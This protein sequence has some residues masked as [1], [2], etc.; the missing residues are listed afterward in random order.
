MQVVAHI[1][2]ISA[3][4]P[5]QYP[6]FSPENFQSKNFSQLRDI[7][8]LSIDLFLF[9]PTSSV[10]YFC[11][12]IVGFI[13]CVRKQSRCSHRRSGIADASTKGGRCKWV[14]FTP[15]S[16]SPAH[17]DAFDCGHGEYVITAVR[18][19]FGGGGA[20]RGQWLLLPL[21]LICHIFC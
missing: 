5:D 9:P 4:A 8:C 13:Q 3:L 10:Y 20:Q 16:G 15:H 21:I 2:E 1:S 18:L 17:I 7:L 6:F 11:L 19:H 14:I 12:L